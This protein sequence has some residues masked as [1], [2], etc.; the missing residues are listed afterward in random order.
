MSL[1]FWSRI[2]SAPLTIE[3]PVL[4][5]VRQPILCPS[6]WGDQTMLVYIVPAIRRNGTWSTVVAGPASR[7]ELNPDYWIPSKEPIT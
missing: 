4:V 5:W 2:E 1:D 7:L 3:T 6:P